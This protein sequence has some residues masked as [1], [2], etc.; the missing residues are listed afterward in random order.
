LQTSNT[1]PRDPPP[2]LQGQRRLPALSHRLLLRRCYYAEHH[3]GY[4][5]TTVTKLHRP[6]HPA[7]YHRPA[8]PQHQHTR[9]FFSA[10]RKRPR[11]G[12]PHIVDTL[13]AQLLGNTPTRPTLPKPRIVWTPEH[14]QLLDLHRDLICSNHA[15]TFPPTFDRQ[16]ALA[17]EIRRSAAACRRAAYDTFCAAL[18]TLWDAKNHRDF[19]AAIKQLRLISCDIGVPALT[20]AV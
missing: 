7:R 19:H 5:R 3:H 9:V 4:P 14:M 17:I 12:G 8:T 13:H 11:I 6:Q 18:Q 2:H 15:F 16:P 20:R 10:P 1:V